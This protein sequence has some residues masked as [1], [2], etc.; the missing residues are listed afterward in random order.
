ML[1]ERVIE[2]AG[3]VCPVPTSEITPAMSLYGDLG[4]S[5]LEIVTFVVC[6]EK[7]FGIALREQPITS[8]TTIAEVAGVIE[9]IQQAMAS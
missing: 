4:L 6:L 5:S 2:L 3:N 7:E 8:M 9:S 1:I